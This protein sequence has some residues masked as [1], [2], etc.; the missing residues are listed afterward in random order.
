MRLHRS[1]TELS[2]A[3][4]RPGATRIGTQ[5]AVDGKVP[6]LTLI[7]LADALGLSGAVPDP[8]AGDRIRTDAVGPGGFVLFSAAG[9]PRVF[10]RFRPWASDVPGPRL[11]GTTLAPVKCRRKRTWQDARSGAGRITLLTVCT[12]E[13]YP[14]S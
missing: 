7:G 13:A 6:E 9:M 11:P 14:P 10:A 8:A 2:S 4:P 3:P 5:H 12:G 1:Y